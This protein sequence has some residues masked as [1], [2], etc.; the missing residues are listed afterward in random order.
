MKIL[1]TIPSVLRSSAGPSYSVIR[2]CENLLNDNTL[3]LISSDQYKQENPDYLITFPISYGLEK[4]GYSPKM[5]SWL[6]SAL[7]SQ[8]FDLVH[9]HSLWMLQNIY[10]SWACSRNNIPIVISPR[11]TLS[12]HAFNSGTRLKKIFWPLIQK[13]ALKNT[14]IFHATSEKE[15]LDIRKLGFKQPIA[16]IPNGIDLP[17]KVVTTKKLKKLLFLGRIHPIKGIDILLESWSLVEKKYPEWSLDIVGPDGYGYLS[18]L[19]KIK[20]DL[21]LKR[22]QFLKEISG[23][24]KLLKYQSSSIFILP[25]HSE[26]FGVSVA[27][28][29][30]NGIPCIVS[31][32]APW[33][34][35]DYKKAGWWIE[36]KKEEIAK[37]LSLAFELE[38]QELQKMGDNGREWMEEEFNWKNIASKMQ[39]IY[40]W[41]L[42]GK[43]M[44][45]YIHL[46]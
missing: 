29:L 27:E 20:E 9:N 45:T 19:K 46:D 24:D 28:A 2:L 23:K 35:L 1:H 11:G 5:Y 38:E 42:T 32:G 31:F 40:K 10:P 18:Y 6:L 16:V 3:T 12:K 36:N 30:A 26:N 22:V 43:N 17:N 14:T 13:P 7:S 39:E 21:G 34:K 8:K 4:L 15:K 37:T 41:T 33:E 44:P 25:S